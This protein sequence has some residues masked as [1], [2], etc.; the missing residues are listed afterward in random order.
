MSNKYGYFKYED[1]ANGAEEDANLSTPNQLQEGADLNFLKNNIRM[2]EYQT[3]EQNEYVTRNPQIFR[4]PEYSIGFITSDISDGNGVFQNP[5]VVK[6]E[7]S[8]YFSMTGLT[9]LTRNV[10]KKA[11]IEGY[12]DGDL[13]ASSYFSA[14]NKNYF[15]PIELELVNSIKFIVFE[16]EEPY[17]FF[18]VYSIRYGRTKTLS[19]EDVVSAKITN[20]FSVFGDSLEYD[21]L[22]V[23]VKNPTDIDAYLFQRKQAINYIKDKVYDLI[24]FI[25]S[26]TKNQNGTASI[27]AYD[28]I[29]NLEDTF[30]GGI[31]NNTPVY[32]IIKAICGDRILFN[33]NADRTIPLT[34]YIPKCTRRKALQMVLLAANLRCYKGERLVFAPIETETR[35]EIFNEENIVGEPKIT[36]NEAIRSVKVEYHTY[37][38]SDDESEVHRWYIAQN[39]NVELTFDG[40]FYGYSAYEVTGVDENGFDIISENVSKNVRFV[41]TGANYCVVYNTS[42]N[43]ILIRAKRYE[44]SK[45]TYD[46]VNKFV[47]RH[48]VYEDIVIDMQL[49]GDYEKTCQMLYDLYAKK[50][51][52]AFKTLQEPVVGGLYNILGQD[53]YIKK[54]KTSLDGIYEVEAV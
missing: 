13:V 16:I 15:Y 1:F 47:L 9:I 5:I 3:L 40:P 6:I 10:V 25:D 41:E 17:H 8:E 24:F 35:P 54:K 49:H 11:K 29:S 7:F 4:L 26:G 37:S 43:K 34:G 18:G 52:I 50:N 38:K 2:P 48:E 36:N 22:D 27:S 14:N 51:S 53:Y 45:S 20:N 19:D 39:E 44:D 31:Y 12:R 23:T 33:F 32:D 46:V 28:S 30:L 21:I 42:P